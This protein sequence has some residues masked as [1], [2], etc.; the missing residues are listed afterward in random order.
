MMATTTSAGIADT[1][2]ETTAEHPIVLFD[3]VCNYCNSILNYIIKH[4]HKKRFR[5][6][7]LQS[8][9]GQDL[10]EQ[11]GFPRDMLDSVVL[12]ENGKAYI[13]TDVTARV[14]PH[15]SGIAKL[16]VVLR[17]VPRAIRDFA[18]DIIARN[19]YKWWGKQ[20]ACIVPTPDVRDRFL[21]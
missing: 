20:D 19:R 6:A 14:A 10:L 17:F 12:I 15:L 3:G 8:N 18:Y 21:S 2:A 16:G 7:H 9:T 11:Y 13:K 4:D 5:Y 1:S